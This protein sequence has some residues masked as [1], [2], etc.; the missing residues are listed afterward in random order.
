MVKAY[1]KK[2]KKKQTTIVVRKKTND[3]DDSMAELVENAE[4]K[5]L[6]KEIQGEIVDKLAYSFAGKNAKVEGLTFWGMKA[7]TQFSKKKTER[8]TPEWTEPKYTQLSE[9]SVLLTIGCINPKVK[10]TEWGNCVFNPLARFSERIA[11]TNAKR[12]A[13]DKWLSIPQKIALVHFLKQHKPK[14]ILQKKLTSDSKSKTAF[15]VSDDG[16]V[17]SKSKAEGGTIN[18]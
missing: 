11:L 14:Q 7:C 18:L 13:L 15:T 3:Y 6:L 16:K 1:K 5:L 2:I 4:S 17:K 10:K 12:Y 9:K 8:W